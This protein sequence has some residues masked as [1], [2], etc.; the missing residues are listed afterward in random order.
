MLISCVFG[1]Q[2]LDFAIRSGSFSHS[3][4]HSDYTRNDI[5]GGSKDTRIM[6]DKKASES[7]KE[8]TYKLPVLGQKINM[9]FNKAFLQRNSALSLASF[10]CK[11]ALLNIMFIFSPRTGNLYVCC[12][13]RVSRT[14]ATSLS[15]KQ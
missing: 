7:N 3:A 6:A 9:I 12:G 14:S 4:K 1:P 13:I 15:Q 2:S 5:V 11:K 10:L 8:H